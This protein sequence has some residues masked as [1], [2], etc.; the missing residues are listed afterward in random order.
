[1]KTGKLSAQPCPF[2]SRAS[3]L[4][5]RPVTATYRGTVLTSSSIPDITMGF[6][7]ITNTYFTVREPRLPATLSDIPHIGILNG[8]TS[9]ENNLSRAYGPFPALLVVI[10][11]LDS[12]PTSTLPDLLNITSTHI[13]QHLYQRTMTPTPKSEIT[14]SLTEGAIRK[15]TRDSVRFPD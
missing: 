9:P 10:D 11:L 15:G 5:Q 7:R 13:R 2:A 1:M 12:R 6:P 4:H 14:Y 8:R 3:L